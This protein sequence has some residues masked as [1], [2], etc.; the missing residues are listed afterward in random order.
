MDCLYRRPSGLTMQS[1]VR[2]GITSAVNL[3]K[4]L[5]GL[6]GKNLSLAR[7]LR[8]AL[9][10]LAGTPRNAPFHRPP[11][12]SPSFSGLRGLPPA[13]LR[14]RKTGLLSRTRL[15]LSSGDCLLRW[16]ATS[17]SRP[18]DIRQVP[19]ERHYLAIYNPPSPAR[20]ASRR[21]PCWRCSARRE[22]ARP[23]QAEAR[24]CSEAA[25]SRR[26]QSHRQI[27]GNRGRQ[28]I[29]SSRVGAAEGNINADLS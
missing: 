26:M 1:G 7:L 19:V 24:R 15:A 2:Q 17:L 23:M 13:S 12:A 25:T 8:A 28:G 5:N 14:L 29:C 10:I 4:G 3:Q 6:F 9:P 22:T 27:S 20:A 21:A 16:T 18:F 11:L